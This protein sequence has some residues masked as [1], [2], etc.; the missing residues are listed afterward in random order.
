M[1]DEVTEV[2]RLFFFLCD[3]NLC[4]GVPSSR[5]NVGFVMAP[6]V[7]INF[8]GICRHLIL[9][10]RLAH[11]VTRP[12]SDIPQLQHLFPH[13][14]SNLFINSIR[15]SSTGRREVKATKNTYFFTL[16]DGHH[17]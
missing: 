6:Y 3:V 11:T 14:S 10:R 9:R 16:P 2:V 5:M 7:S 1:C 17:A 8:I 15:S 12:S 4:T 13:W